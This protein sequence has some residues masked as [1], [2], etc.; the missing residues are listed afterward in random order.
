MGTPRLPLPSCIE[1][2]F[3]AWLTGMVRCDAPDRARSPHSVG[4]RLFTPRWCEQVMRSF[5]RA[6]PLKVDLD[7]SST[8][9]EGSECDEEEVRGEEE[10]VVKDATLDLASAKA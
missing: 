5:N 8:A 9:K 2:A 7:A 1:D 10:E 4:R 3:L 6:Y